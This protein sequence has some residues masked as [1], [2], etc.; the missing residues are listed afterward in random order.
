MQGPLWEAVGAAQAGE[1]S[2]TRAGARA[3]EQEVGSAYVGTQF[4]SEEHGAPPV[5][6]FQPVYTL[7]SLAQEPNSSEKMAW[8]ESPAV[9]SGMG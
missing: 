7:V 3:W 6:E 2:R 9:F 8:L 5:S 4:Q 1:Q